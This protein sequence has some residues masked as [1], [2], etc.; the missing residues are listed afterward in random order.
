MTPTFRFDQLYII[1]DL[2]FGGEPGFQIFGSPAEMTWLLTHLADL[3]PG[4]EIGLVI[5][6]DFIDFL[7]ENPPAYFDPHG[8]I[9]K[10]D[11]IALEDDTFK[12]IFSAFRYFLSK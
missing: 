2:H 3:D 12:P 5:N 9:K 7:A 11:R 1:S 6:G 4:A 10:L 8:A